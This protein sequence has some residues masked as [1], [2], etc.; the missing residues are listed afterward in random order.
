MWLPAY[1]YIYI[2]IYIDV[3]YTIMLHARLKNL[4]AAPHKTAALQ[5]LASYL[6]NYPSKKNK[7]GWALLEKL[8]SDVLLW[9][10]THGHTSVSQQAKTSGAV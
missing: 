8:V 5:L 10:P 7:T 9:T 2:Y 3:S 1:I 6:T 4:E